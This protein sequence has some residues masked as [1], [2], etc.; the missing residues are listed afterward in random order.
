MANPT[1]SRRCSGR[2]RHSELHTGIAL[3]RACAPILPAHHSIYHLKIRCRHP[4][5]ER[6][7]FIV[8]SVMGVISGT[9]SYTY[10]ILYMTVNCWCIWEPSRHR[11]GEIALG[12]PLARYYDGDDA[13][14]GH[15]QRF[16]RR[17]W[18]LCLPSEMDLLNSSVTSER[19][20][21]YR[22]LWC[23]PLSPSPPLLGEG[24]DLWWGYT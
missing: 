14:D 8:I 23:S 22:L 5:R 20:V 18:Q 19:H 7:Q 3:C 12:K 13:N 16:S 24:L 17:R 10:G 15:L 4:F 9:F 11:H 2:G 1:S 21:F 6:P